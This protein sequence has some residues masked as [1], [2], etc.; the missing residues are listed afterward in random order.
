MR[1]LTF[2]AC[3]A[4]V[5]SART[6]HAQSAS[7]R[8]EGTITDSIRRRP[9]AGAMLIAFPD[10]GF[11]DTIF[12]SAEADARGR[13]AFADLP[14]GGYR[15]TAEHPWLDST[16]LVVPWV[17]VHVPPS[18]TATADLTVPSARTLRHSL[19]A[20]AAADTTLGVMLGVVRRVDG[21]PIPGA[22]VVFT[23]TDEKVER[24]S[25]TITK[26]QLNAS[27]RADST[28][29]YRACGLPAERTVLAQAQV[30]RNAHSGV[31]EEHIGTAGVLVRDFHVDT[32]AVTVH[33]DAG[34]FAITGHVGDRDGNAIAS[35]HVRLFRGSL[36]AVTNTA[37]EFRLNGLPGGIQGFEVEVAGYF[38]KRFRAELAGVLDAIAIRVERIPGPADS[39][40]QAD[41]YREFEGRRANVVGR[42]LT[43]EDIARRHPF[44]LSDIVLAG[45]D[46]QNCVSVF[47]N[48]ERDANGDVDLVVPES[49]HGVEVFGRG[50]VPTKYSAKGC[51]VVLIW[52]R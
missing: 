9:F 19:C 48:G 49:I 10:A 15:V 6:A 13:F 2:L 25:A 12:H 41:N 44:T 32:A 37:G 42:Y 3:L 51:A 50:E 16:G 31:I 18:G 52:T 33:V 23:W 26:K 21:N 46:G 7:G 43:E 29:V 4:V 20:A 11:R 5:S 39:A 36:A 17:R 30:G 34:R 45:T 24:E 35:A 38:T 22:N 40:R 28:G 1:A 27:V 14:A 8:I 47:Y